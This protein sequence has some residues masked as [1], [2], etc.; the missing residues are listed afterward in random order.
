LPDAEFVTIPSPDAMTKSLAFIFVCRIVSAAVV[1][2]KRL[3]TCDAIYPLAHF[4]P[5]VLPAFLASRRRTAVIVHHMQGPPWKRAGN[6][7]RNMLAYANERLGLALTRRFA[8]VVVVVNH[9][10]E[11]ELHLPPGRAV[12]CSGNGTWT[13][14][15]DGA[16]RDLEERSGAVFVGRFH[17]TKGILDLIEAW[18]IVLERVPNARLTLVGKGEP[19]YVEIVRG[20][21]ASLGLEGSIRMAGRVTN[22][23]K[24]QII[25]SAR[26]FAT[27]TKEEG[28]G[29][30][31]AE[32][33]ALGTPCVTYDLPVFR[34]VF[35]R[36][37][38][39]V[40]EGDVRAFAAA[41][42]TLLTD[43]AAFR[44]LAIEA[45][46]LGASFSWDH[47]ARVEEE[48]IL[49]VAR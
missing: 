1:L 48:A 47:V 45:R 5:D 27:A 16:A 32:A 11:A 22:E 7:V 41:V 23:Q 39:E 28:W 14:P 42:V 13:T 3:R 25:G 2:P 44:R 15:V 18:P 43:D 17:P 24:A 21:I 33:M 29:I 6:L 46:E 12:F 40:A 20:R 37:R 8:R 36:G 34:D 10:V 26:V 30:A 19:A 38:L 31:T 49:A 4:F 9:L 35:P